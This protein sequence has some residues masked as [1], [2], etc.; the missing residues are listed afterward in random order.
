MFGRGPK[1]IRM[2]KEK[3]Q[4]TK[5]K[6]SPVIVP[7]PN[8]CAWQPFFHR[9]IFANNRFASMILIELLIM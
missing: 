7:S 2:S 8:F 9:F 4:K 3:H 6:K 5:Q 1:Q